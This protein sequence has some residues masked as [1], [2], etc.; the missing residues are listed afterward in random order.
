MLFVRPAKA[1]LKKHQPALTAFLQPAHSRGNQRHGEG[2]NIATYIRL[3]PP[4]SSHLQ[5][6]NGRLAHHKKLPLGGCFLRK[7][8]PRQREASRSVTFKQKILLKYLNKKFQERCPVR[9]RFC[10]RRIGRAI[11]PRGLW[12]DGHLFPI[13]LVAREL[14]PWCAQWVVSL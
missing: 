6:A 3:H 9:L 2:G 11:V 1:P 14:G 8:H 7:N 12:N 10:P 5:V 13:E 4:E